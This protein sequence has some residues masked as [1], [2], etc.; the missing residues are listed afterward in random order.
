MNFDNLSLALEPEAAAIYCQHPDFCVA[1][2]SPLSQRYVVLDIGGGTIDITAQ[3]REGMTGKLDVLCV[4]TGNSLGGTVVNEEF[5][6]LLQQIVNDD[7]FHRFINDPSCSLEKARNRAVINQL[8]YKEFED[9][10]VNF[11]ERATYEDDE[12]EMKITL[13]ARFSKF[14]GDVIK[15]GVDALKD[16]RVELDDG[17]ILCI[18]YG[19][20]KELFKPAMDSILQYAVSV[21][22]E[23]KSKVDTVYLVGGFGGSR[24]VYHAIRDALSNDISIIVPK[25]HI[26][27]IAS[28]A[29]IW[30]ENPHLITSRRADATYGISVSKPF[31]EGVHDPHYLFVNGEGEKRCNKVFEVY[32]EKG[33]VVLT[34]QV[35]TNTITPSRQNLTTMTFDLYCTPS[36]GVQYV[37]DKNGDPTV[38]KIGHLA[39]DIPNPDN[40][41]RRERKVELTWDFSSTEIRVRARYLVTG[42]EVKC[43]A[44]FLNAQPIS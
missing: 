14:Y 38:S 6:K 19:K 41:A 26:V 32:L 42:M 17:D 36:I 15:A 29:V 20:V 35:F 4:P 30:R 13:P 44:D 16:D 33:E 27:A 25:E 22:S 12:D 31:R 21:I 24:Y 37:A 7:N 43:I 40:L 2:T 28:G 18:K 1:A 10:K 34:G 3:R 11:G 39:I 8:L 23:L 5:S 9:E